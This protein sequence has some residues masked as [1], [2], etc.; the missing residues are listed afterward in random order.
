MQD[1]Y[2]LTLNTDPY[3]AAECKVDTVFHVP[4]CNHSGKVGRN[5]YSNIDLEGY[6]KFLFEKKVI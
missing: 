1:K 6:S 3:P 4:Q 5:Q 2:G